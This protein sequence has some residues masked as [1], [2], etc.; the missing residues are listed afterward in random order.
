MR[1]FLF[2]LTTL[3]SMTA[4]AQKPGAFAGTYPATKTTDQSDIFFGTKVS[5]P[6]RWLEND[7]AEDTRDW[8]Q[9]QNK[10]SNAYLSKIPYRDAI[11]KRLTDL[12][13]Y[14]K[15]SAPF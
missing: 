12:W 13:N 9:R 10:V 2:C 15:F 8:V 11:K 14:E 4:M 6:Y 5:D 1:L 3:L 7:M